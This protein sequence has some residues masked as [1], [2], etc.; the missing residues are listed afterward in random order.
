M[1]D[2][3]VYEEAFGDS[4]CTTQQD[5]HNS[6]RR[7]W[8]E[9]LRKDVDNWNR[10]PPALRSEEFAV[11]A[12][13]EVRTPALYRHFDEA[14][15]KSA[16]VLRAL[17]NLGWATWWVSNFGTHR[18]DRLAAVK[19][20]GM[21]FS[22]RRDLNDIEFLQI[23]VD[24]NPEVLMQ[25]RDANTTRKIEE[26][27]LFGAALHRMPLLWQEADNLGILDGHQNNV[28]RTLLISGLPRHLILNELACLFDKDPAPIELL[29][30]VWRRGLSSPRLRKSQTALHGQG[31]IRRIKYVY[32]GG[33]IGETAPG[34]C[35]CKY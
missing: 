18:K 12:L 3:L 9:M 27:G 35:Q 14:L 33:Q 21:K 22:E 25:L 26:A 6:L 32:R 29:E 17:D 5:N 31:V 13:R 24:T 19:A 34:N 28:A 2:P 11:Q 15:R 23:L 1:T 8:M 7:E 4:D 30:V 10:I 16:C 20:A